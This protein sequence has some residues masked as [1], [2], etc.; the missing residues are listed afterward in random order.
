MMYLQ[1]LRLTHSGQQKAVLFNLLTA[2]WVRCWGRKWA[3][4]AHAKVDMVLRTVLLQ[5]LRF[6]TVHTGPEANA[7][8]IDATI[9]SWCYLELV[10]TQYLDVLRSHL[11]ELKQPIGA[12]DG[13]ENS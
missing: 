2:F 8:V 4:P 11:F 5:A 10:D 1:K 6:S 7:D 12:E 9:C 13:A 3:P